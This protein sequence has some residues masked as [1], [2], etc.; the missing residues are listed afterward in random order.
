MGH[1]EGPGG[2]GKPPKRLSRDVGVAGHI[3]RDAVAAIVASAEI[4][5]VKK[6]RASGIDLG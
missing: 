3:H 6:F 2:R 1:L 5:G 4:G